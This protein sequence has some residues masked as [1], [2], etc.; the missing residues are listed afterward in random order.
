MSGG[1]LISFGVQRWS[2]W[3]PGLDS[4]EKWLSWFDAPS[5][6]PA[7][8]EMAPLPWMAPLQRR[9]L[10]P[11]GRAL[12]QVAHE[13]LPD[14]GFEG[15]IVLASGWG[16]VGRAVTMLQSLASGQGVSPTQFS[17]SVHNAAV[18]QHAIA[19]QCRGNIT[20]LSGADGSAHAGLLEALA[21]IKDGASRV[22]LLS[23]EQP[24][25]ESYAAELQARPCADV[26]PS[27]RAWAV[28][29]DGQ[30]QGLSL[31]Q[32]DDLALSENGPNA[33]LDLLAFLVG[34]GRGVSHAL[35]CGG[36]SLVRDPRCAA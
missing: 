11:F 33:S 14:I 32:G 26:V 31:R 18:A 12:F 30:A 7:S 27:L 15:P 16:E 13:V 1:A 24:V 20:A 28:V 23:V 21:L 10:E 3:A 34:A 4:N 35:G 8:A 5:S 6:I 17:L 22:I 2:A 19:Q 36:F 25:P 29:L 9:R